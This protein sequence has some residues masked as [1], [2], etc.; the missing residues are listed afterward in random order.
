VRTEEKCIERPGKI[1]MTDLIN[2]PELVKN[3]WMTS[4][5]N[6]HSFSV[7]FVLTVL[8]GTWRVA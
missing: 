2:F 8:L 6:V 4:S 1:N 5:R 7:I 3:I